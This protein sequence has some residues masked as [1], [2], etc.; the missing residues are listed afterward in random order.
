MSL[1]W[2]QKAFFQKLAN[3]CKQTWDNNPL[4]VIQSLHLIRF[5]Q[6]SKAGG[7]A[8][9]FCKK[10]EVCKSDLEGKANN[11]HYCLAYNPLHY[12]VV[13]THL[14]DK[15]NTQWYNLWLQK[16][17]KTVSNF[18]FFFLESIKKVSKTSTQ[19]E[20]NRGF[21]KYQPLFV[22]KLPSVALMVDRLTK[23]CAL[24]QTS[25]QLIHLPVNGVCSANHLF[26]TSHQWTK[27]S[28]LYVYTIFCVWNM[29]T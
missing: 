7:L 29:P 5:T 27:Y 28:L 13:S 12:T 2:N 26:E 9:W 22:F 6:Y 3:L 17:V 11:D 18:N 24:L 19:A 25:P 8:C 23:V 14:K 16:A 15:W 20:M 21:H 10:T 1:N 4:C